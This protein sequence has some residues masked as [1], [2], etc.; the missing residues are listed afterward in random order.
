M[1]I[2]S[3]KLVY[4]SPT[5]TTGKIV[6]NI[7]AGI[8]VSTVERFNLTPSVTESAEYKKATGGLAIIGA[9]VYGGRMPIDAVNRFKR[10]RANDVPAVVVIVYGNREYDDALLELKNLAE[11]QG[12]IP[13]AGGAFI[14]EH[15]YSTDTMP[16]AKGR[17]DEMD[18]TRAQEFGKKVS[19]LLSGVDSVRSLSPLKLPG[20]YPYKERVKLFADITPFIDEMLCTKCEI[21]IPICPTGSITMHDTLQINPSTC[22]HC[23]ACTKGCPSKALYF[24][25]PMIKGVTGWLHETCSKRKEP[26]IYLS[27]KVQSQGILP[28]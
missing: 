18:V 28:T 19:I 22:T 24:D 8:K 11:E 10:F 1:E 25:D 9:P 20:N 15:S 5:G 12:F 4:F 27:S 3:L 13:V 6:E 21:C 7:A 26:E 14:G 23:C 16:I 2:D 17:P